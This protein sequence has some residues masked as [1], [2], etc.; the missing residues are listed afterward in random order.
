MNT[1]YNLLPWDPRV[2]FNNRLISLESINNTNEYNIAKGLNAKDARVSGDAK[3]FGFYAKYLEGVFTVFR[4]TSGRFIIGW[5]DQYIDLADI[6]TM[7]WN[8]DNYSLKFTCYDFDNKVILSISYVT[9]WKYIVN[10]FKILVLFLDQITAYTDDDFY[11]SCDLPEDIRT[12]FLRNKF[13]DE[14]DQFLITRYEY[15]IGKSLP[16]YWNDI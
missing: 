11:Y 4:D 7:E 8:R 1:K 16:Y 12:I 13:A 15:W 2:S 9:L 3:V 6:E 5:Q 10:P 14:F